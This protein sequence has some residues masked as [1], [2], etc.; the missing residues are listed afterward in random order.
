MIDRTE[1]CFGLKPKRLAVDTAC[2]T[3]K[4]LG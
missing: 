1:V 3:G 2:G 4:F